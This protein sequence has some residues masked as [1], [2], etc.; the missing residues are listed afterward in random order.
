M[1]TEKSRREGSWGRFPVARSISALHQLSRLCRP[2]LDRTFEW[3]RAPVQIHRQ[4]KGEE[5]IT[6]RI[7]TELQPFQNPSEEIVVSRPP[8]AV[9][10]YQTP[11]ER[12]RWSD[13]GFGGQ[14]ASRGISCH[15]R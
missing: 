15:S 9:L 7:R 14:N 6:A 2:W 11:K 5:S 12:K 8:L 10:R 1:K 13:T 4:P 3:Q